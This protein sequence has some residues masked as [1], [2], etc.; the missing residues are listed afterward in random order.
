MTEE[1]KKN[2]LGDLSTRDL[3]TEEVRATKATKKSKSTKKVKKLLSS[4]NPYEEGTLFYQLYE[5]GLTGVDWT[6]KNMVTPVKNQGRCGSCWAFAVVGAV[7][8]AHT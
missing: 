4:E 8:A 3:T 6:K 1:E 2:Y 7:E 5:E